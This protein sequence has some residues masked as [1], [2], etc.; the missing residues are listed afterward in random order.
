LVNDVSTQTDSSFRIL[1]NDIINPKC[2]GVRFESVISRNNFIV[3]NVII[4][5]GDYLLEGIPSYI[6][7]EDP[8]SEV[9][10][11]NNYLR[12]DTINA[13]FINGTY[14]QKAGSPLIDAGYYQG[15]GVTFDY[16]NNPR[17]IG[18]GFDIGI[19]E[20][21]SEITGIQ[22]IATV[23]DALR[24]YPNPAR[25]QMN[26]DYELLVASDVILDI[27]SLEGEKLLTKVQT[28]VP[29]GNHVIS[30]DVVALS[31]GIYMFRLQTGSKVMTGRFIKTLN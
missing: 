4:N 10:V 25:V 13:G 27:Y 18:V 3:S 14:E 29:A 31:S 16:N 1:F 23:T 7:I 12:L 9:T 11:S 28:S 20:F 15:E 5:P 24:S 17:P 2:D 21:N 22:S 6:E 19:Y 26:I 30:Q 8:A